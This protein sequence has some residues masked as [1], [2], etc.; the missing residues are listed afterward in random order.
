MGIVL[1][2]DF[3]KKKCGIAVSDLTQTIASALITL[4]TKKVISF[5]NNYDKDN[6][7]S[8]IV[9][10]F[11]MNLDCSPTDATQPTLNF[12]SKLKREF[13]KIKIDL[14]DERF[15]S[16]IAFQ[17]L[18]DLGIKK[19]KRRDKMIL[20]KISATLILQTYLDKKNRK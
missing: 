5:I 13:K 14:I 16:K 8:E 12:V 2:V 18:I 6:K 17:T 10:G 9:V 7:L 11:P 20:D 1:S 3:G 15:T 4:E 19:K